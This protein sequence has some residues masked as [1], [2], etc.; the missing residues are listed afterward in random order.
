MSTGIKN[1]KTGYFIIFARFMIERHLKLLFIPALFLLLL[2]GG[3][4]EER[5]AEP[6][7]LPKVDP[8]LFL[9]LDSAV[10]VEKTGK[11]EHLF[12]RL[13]KR[14]GFNGTVLYA[15]KGRVIFQKAY[16][17]RNPRR[18]KDSLRVDDAFQLASVSKMFSA[19]GIMI[20]Q[21]E[22]KLDYD[23]DIREYLPDFPYE[24]VTCR[25]LMTHRAGLPRYMSI[26]HEKWKNKKIP[27]DNDD[28]LDLFITYQPDRYFRPNT[29]F[30]YCNTNY[31]LLANIIEAVSGMHFEDFMKTRVFDPLG[32]TH[33][34]VY[35]MRGDTAV[36]LYIDRGV[37]GYYHR[38]WRLRE[39]ENDY[40]N[41]V[42]GDKNVYT[43]VTDLYKFDRALDL[44]TLLPDSVLREAFT[45]GSKKY[46]KRKN[47]YGFGWRLK[48][49]MDSTAYHFGWWKGFRTFYIRDMKHQQT[50]IVLSNKD[51]GPG[52][53][54][55]WN[56]VQSDTLP[57]G[58]SCP[59]DYGKEQEN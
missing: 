58:Y 45:P 25:W 39:M 11:L 59:V 53:D 43:S 57:L 17:W 32:M 51:R 9:D 16:G 18:K 55:F 4:G 15:E 19:I 26:A 21:H 5:K 3:C 46:W 13:E 8:S 1:K 34:F 28:M 48:D 44:G 23:V 10:I 24:D 20:L 56:I 7:F 52:S 2:S 41:G 49:G 22:G 27:L 29:G 6:E 30:H 35:N 12:S 31:A 37:P 33:S 50:L 42:M 47:N 36:P 38:G 14:T 54:N 40:L